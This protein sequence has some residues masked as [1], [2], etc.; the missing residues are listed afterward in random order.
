[1]KPFESIPLQVAAAV[2]AW[3]AFG[4]VAWATLAGLMRVTLYGGM[5]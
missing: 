4:Y 2:V 1:M 5:V 3:M